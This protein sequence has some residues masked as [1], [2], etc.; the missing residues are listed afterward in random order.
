MIDTA[1]AATLALAACGCV[2]RA[3]WLLRFR[4]PATARI[5]FN[6]CAADFRARR[7]AGMALEGEPGR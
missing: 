5:V 3:G 7:A 2:I 6:G 1:A 4:V